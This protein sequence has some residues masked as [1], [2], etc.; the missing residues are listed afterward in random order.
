MKERKQ[1]DVGY[2]LGINALARSRT[3]NLGPEERD[4]GRRRWQWMRVAVNAEAGRR[5]GG[6]VVYG[7][8]RT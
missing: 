7:V 1:P 4:E 2:R 6:I 5:D 8:W 3:S